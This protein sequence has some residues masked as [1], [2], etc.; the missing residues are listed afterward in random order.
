MTRLGWDDSSW[1]NNSIKTFVLLKPGRAAGCLR[2]QDQKHTIDHADPT[3]EVTT[4]VFTQR[5]ADAYLYSRSENGQYVGG[6]IQ[7]V[8]LFGIIAAFILLIA[9]IN[10]MNLSTAR[11]EK[12][13]K[14]VGIRKVVGAPKGTL[15]GQ[16]LGES[17][18]IAL[19]AGI[20][21]I[22]IVQVSLPGLINLL[23]RNFTSIISIPYSGLPDCCSWCLPA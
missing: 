21:A 14:E 2:C 10:F 19:L 22:I 4:Q 23:I 16:F 11:S 8:R 12:R 7:M 17:I 5:L 3:D 13:A 6:R 20:V 18:L 15:V 9:C 1:S